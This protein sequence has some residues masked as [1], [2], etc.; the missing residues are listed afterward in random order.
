MK[1]IYKGLSFMMH[2]LYHIV[3]MQESFESPRCYTEFPYKNMHR[4]FHYSGIL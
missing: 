4:S 3:N 1:H 2:R